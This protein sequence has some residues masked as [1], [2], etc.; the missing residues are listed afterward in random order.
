MLRIIEIHKSYRLQDADGKGAIFPEGIPQQ[1]F[2]LVKGFYAMIY[3]I[4]TCRQG[5]HRAKQVVMEVFADARQVFDSLN[6]VLYQFI[7]VPYA[8]Q[9]QDLRRV[10]SP[11]R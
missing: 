5:A 3:A 11:C 10:K 1:V 4:L 9:H 2:Q 6:L 8:L 7:R